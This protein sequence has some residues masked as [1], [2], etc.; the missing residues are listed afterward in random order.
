MRSIPVSGVTI[1]DPKVLP[2]RVNTA[3]AINI[4]DST[5]RVKPFVSVFSLRKKW[6]NGF[7]GYA[8]RL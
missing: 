2:P 1:P 4:S 6:N 8:V 7:K 5:V 3:E